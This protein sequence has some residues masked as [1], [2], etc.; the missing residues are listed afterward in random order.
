MEAKIED[1]D[2][3]RVGI[4]GEMCDLNASDETGEHYPMR[5]QVSQDG[6][7]E[8]DIYFLGADGKP[9]VKVACCLVEG[10]LSVDV[11]DYA[12][13]GPDDVPCGA[14]A[15]ASASIHVNPEVDP[16]S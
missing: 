13:L 1:M 2:V 14:E 3:P 16:W 9:R 11:I 7:G 4:R 6:G 10:N 12:K 5:F 15:V 8:L